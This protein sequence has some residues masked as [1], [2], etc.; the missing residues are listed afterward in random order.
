MA[1]HR[2]FKATVLTLVTMGAAGCAKS[3]F[4][5]RDRAY[6]QRSMDRVAER[7]PEVVPPKILPETFFAA[8]R[9]FE[10][11]GQ[12]GLA[13]V[14]YRKAV[15]V[16][17]NYTD[18]YHRLGLMLS[19]AGQ[20]DEAVEALSKAVRLRPDDAIL[21]NNLGF[22]LMLGE[23]WAEAE[24]EFQRA[25][26][27]EPHFARAQIN[28]GMVLAKLGRYEEALASFQTV[29][30]EVDARYNLGL[31]LR[32]Q[33]RYA[34]AADSFEYV[35]NL[36]PN[37][38]AASTQL[39]QMGMTG[40]R[41]PASG[42]TIGV[43]SWHTLATPAE[44]EFSGERTAIAIVSEDEN[45]Y[46]AESAEDEFARFSREEETDESMG[47][48]SYAGTK[49]GSMRAF[50]T[51]QAME[52]ELS[53]IRNEIACLEA[54]GIANAEAVVVGRPEGVVLGPPYP[55]FYWVTDE[56]TPMVPH[57]QDEEIN[58]SVADEPGIMSYADMASETPDASMSTEAA[59]QRPTMGM[60]IIE[61]AEEEKAEQDDA[62]GPSDA[63]APTEES[64][65][66]PW[67]T[68]RQLD[69]L[70]D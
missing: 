51:L 14:Q 9:L 57:S 20:R 56:L 68:E 35:L 39:W 70:R 27:L 26:E 41:V 44:E 61:P 54:E 31:M 11:Q 67:A 15:A 19:L 29:L 49:T 45:E 7:T 59:S 38:V 30:P 50:S 63:D 46:A 42:A 23:R 37:F 53:I 43:P 58:Y 10:H 66:L 12:V 60:T 28:R 52:D 2:N 16:N 34:E 48:E 64:E 69:P 33:Q 5:G 18:A 17:H 1:Y 47:L 25:V 13:I 3:D 4:A 24:L 65:E 62:Y 21:R 40:D 22:E 8:G 6:R 32:G 36:D 55:P